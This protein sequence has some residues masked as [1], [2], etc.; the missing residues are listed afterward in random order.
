MRKKIFFTFYFFIVSISLFAQQQEEEVKV[1]D[2]PPIA[3]GCDPE[4]D[5]AQLKAC[6]T[7]IVSEQIVNK[8]NFSYIRKQDLKPGQYTVRT[9]FSIDSKGRVRDVRAEF[10]NQK[11]AK[12]FVRAVK[13]IATVEP[14]Y[15]DG[16]PVKIFYTMPFK[17]GID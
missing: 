8:L 4:A 15:L 13:S 6:F 7:R 1:V 12:H 10:P 11:I 3:R 14:A 2:T 16:E 9:F 5:N 17:F